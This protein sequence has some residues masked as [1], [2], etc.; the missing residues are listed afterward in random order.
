MEVVFR[1]RRA[2]KSLGGGTSQIGFMA[3]AAI[4]ALDNNIDR[5]KIDHVHT[6]MIAQGI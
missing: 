4:Y 3:A 6:Q 5:L 1:A 2:R